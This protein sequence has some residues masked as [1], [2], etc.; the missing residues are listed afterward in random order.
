MERVY[1]YNDELMHTAI[2]IILTRDDQLMHRVTNNQDYK[3]LEDYVLQVARRVVN[4]IPSNVGSLFTELD[5]FKTNKIKNNNI[6]E[7]RAKT[8]KQDKANTKLFQSYL[9]KMEQDVR[10]QIANEKP[11]LLRK[12]SDERSSPMIFECIKYA[13]SEKY[14]ALGISIRERY[15][16][17]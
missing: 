9:V 4:N 11:E 15:A 7:I 5:Q 14:P 17:R 3:M 1:M 16:K 13:L 8:T 2:N 6:M 12:F 10:E